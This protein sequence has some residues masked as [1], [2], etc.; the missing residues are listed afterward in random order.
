MIK[1]YL[2]GTFKNNVQFWAKP[3]ANYK[4]GWHT[5]SIF[6]DGKE[7]HSKSTDGVQIIDPW[8]FFKKISENFIGE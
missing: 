2:V 1:S 5:W 4:Y 7:N 3:D 8:I 6:P